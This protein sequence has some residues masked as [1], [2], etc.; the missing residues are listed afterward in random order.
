VKICAALGSA[1]QGS[2][3]ALPIGGADTVVMRNLAL[4]VLLVFAT[5]NPAAQNRAQLDHVGR[6]LSQKGFELTTQIHTGELDHE[7]N[8]EVSVRLRAGVRYAIVGVCD[9]DCDDLDI[10]LYT[11]NGREL[12]ADVEDDDVPVV[13]VSPD[14]AGVFM[15]RAVMANCTKSPCHYGLGLFSASVDPFEKQVREQLA[16]A[17]RTL[18]KDGFDLTHTVHVGELRQNQEEDVTAELDRGRTYLIVG[19]CDNDCKDLDLRL[20]NASRQE[21]DRDIE[22]D[23]YPAVGVEATRTEA[24]T[25]RA[26]MAACEKQ[27][28][29]YGFGV[30]A[31]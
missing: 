23:D 13:E 29:R 26:V 12:A 27:P 22:R 4:V 14:Q 19:V 24:F 15:A 25:V 8:E 10:V 20:L 9:S 30:F 3:L 17:A 31:R 7:R 18:G 16:R 21:I 11:A 6:S 1:W 28:C 2:S 5:T